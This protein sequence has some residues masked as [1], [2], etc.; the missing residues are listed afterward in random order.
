ME[1]AILGTGTVGRTL[2]EGLARHGHRVTVGTRDPEATRA[3]DEAAFEGVTLRTFADA[4]ADAELVILATSGQAALGVIEAA[5]PSR[6]AGK[7]LIDVANP[8][9]FS[10]G[11]PP[12]L[13]VCNTTSLGEQV[14]AA[15]PEAKVVKALNT[16][17]AP[18]MIDPASVAGGDHTL[19]ICGDDAE[20]KATVTALLAEL[21]WRDVLDLGPISG[22]RAT[23]A[24]LL[25][26]TRLYAARQSA[27][28]S[29]K[30]VS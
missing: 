12:S 24:Y 19:P 29:I 2:S 14:Q 5:G 15:A 28:F 27:A 17:A 30:V 21:G 16:V 10:N 6:L 7:V 18:V 13:S 26:W 22:A 11:F 4:A 23:E 9:D 3:R 20:A 25:L 1:I 8:L